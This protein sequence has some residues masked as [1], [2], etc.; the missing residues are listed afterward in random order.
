MSEL[1]RA[2]WLEAIFWAYKMARADG[3]TRLE[4]PIYCDVFHPMPQK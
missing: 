2:L 4:W 1:G 3:M